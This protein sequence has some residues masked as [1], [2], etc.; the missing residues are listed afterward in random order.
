MAGGPVVL[1][2]GA[3]MGLGEA[4]AR[5]FARAGY[6]VALAA[7]SADR[8]Q[9]LCAE[10]VAGGAEALALP[11]DVTDPAAVRTVVDRTLAAFGR[12][13]VLV[14]NAGLGLRGD[15]HQV[16]L[17]DLRYV[18]DVNVFGVV[19]CVQAA[20][21][22]MARQGGGL[23]VTISSVAG[24][25]AVPG[26]GGY[27]ATKHAL[28]ALANAMRVELA[29]LGIR[30]MNVLPGYTAT[31]FSAN[32]RGVPAAYRRPVPFRPKTAEAV[33]RQVVRAA[34][35]P[36]RELWTH[37]RER[38]AAAIAGGLPGLADRL[39]IRHRARR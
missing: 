26:A 6:R 21:P 23:I 19:R 29:P 38:L 22:A 28:N 39:L 20:V 17:D 25:F 13:D 2:T 34:A 36:P 9:R 8:L 7:R 14:A 11:L 12:L 31:A 24:R 30:V 18:F 16:D 32:A 3:S 37:P 10:L 1:V 35:R 33:A 4:M 27:S 15:V 5:E